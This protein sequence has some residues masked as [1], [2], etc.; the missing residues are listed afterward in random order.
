MR[1]VGKQRC[2]RQGHGFASI[3]RRS[4]KAIMRILSQATPNA[5]HFSLNA[6][7]PLNAA[8]PHPRK[9]ATPQSH[10]YNHYPTSLPLFDTCECV[11]PCCGAPPPDTHPSRPPRKASMQRLCLPR[12]PS[13]WGLHA[14]VISNL[15][16]VAPKCGVSVCQRHGLAA[17]DVVSIGN[18]SCR[19]FMETSSNPAPVPTK[20]RWRPSLPRPAGWPPSQYL[21]TL[22]SKH[23]WRT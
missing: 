3:D 1:R 17:R 11:A 19:N 2:G 16:C 9:D 15:L 20:M 13:T 22:S 18:S 7:A 6:T 14:D 5:F 23:S 12:P 4:Y 8:A 21:S 10:S